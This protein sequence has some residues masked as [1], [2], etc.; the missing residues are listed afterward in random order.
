MHMISRYDFY[1][2]FLNIFRD[3]ATPPLA[4]AMISDV[5]PPSKRALA[6]AVFSWGI[7]YG[8]GGSFA[9]GTYVQ[10]K[11]IFDQ[12]WRTSY[13]VSGLPGFVLAAVFLL[14]VTEPRNNKAKKSEENPTVIELDEK[15]DAEKKEDTPQEEEDNTPT[16]KILLNLV[17]RPEIL[18]LIVASCIRHSGMHLDNFN[19]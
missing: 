1:N 13:L 19:Y 12:P 5:F 3:A 18:L 15:G 4:A 6:M 17:K 2:I 8:F 11:N 7:Y 9:I 14:T 10:D 16:W